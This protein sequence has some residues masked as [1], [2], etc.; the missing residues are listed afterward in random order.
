MKL[1]PKTFFG[2]EGGGDDLTQALTAPR[3]NAF[4]RREPPDDEDSLPFAFHLIPRLVTEKNIFSRRI[5]KINYL[6][7]SI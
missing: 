3:S 7:Q 4:A 6:Y 2:G 1:Q 5:K